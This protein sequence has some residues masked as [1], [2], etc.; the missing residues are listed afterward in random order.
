MT[1]VRV[2]VPVLQGKRKF[3][4]DKGRPW[5]V[6]EKVVL[7]ALGHKDLTASELAEQANVPRRL[8]V[9]S[10]IR[11]MRAGWIQMI[12]SNTGVVFQPTQ[13]GL[14]A[15]VADE[16]P[17][18]TRRMKRG[19]TFIV[20]QISGGVFRSRELPYLHKNVVQ[21][22]A[23]REP[24]IWM[25][26]PSRTYLD[27]IRPLVDAL[28]QDDERFIAMDP[29]GDRLAERWSL[30]R[31]RDGEP[32]GLSPRASPTLITAIKEA[33]KKW[34][35]GAPNPDLTYAPP[36]DIAAPIRV[37]GTHNLSIMSGDI[38][39]GGPDHR[40]VLES[41]LKK[42]R[43]RVIIHSTFIAEQ[44][45]NDLLPL[46]LD[47]Q[48][49]GAVIDIMWGQGE[50]TAEKKSTQKVALLL[51]AR[52]TEQKIDRIRV[53]PF[54]TDS[55]AKFLLADTG[56]IDQFNCVIGSCNWLYSGFESIE[57]SAKLRDPRIISEI[58]AELGELS[59]GRKG[60]WTDFTND[61]A[62]LSSYLGGLPAPAAG[63]AQVSLV[64]GPQHA[65]Q[66]RSARDEASNRILV[67][68]H[69]LSTTAHNA[70]LAPAIAAA[71][72]RNIAT[73]IYYGIKS[74][75]LTG[76][77]L[78]DIIVEGRQHSIKITPIHDPKL[79]AKLLAWDDDAVVITSQNWLSADPPDDKP[80]AEIGLSIRSPGIARQIID[81]LNAI[82]R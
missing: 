61:L 57:I 59:R 9:E 35:G 5:S 2:A 36:S 51:Q 46:M 38:L 70:V 42:A 53:H 18:V 74:G 40:D 48:K 13:S 7:V 45:F 39:V 10:L 78:S 64:L 50:Q 56:S 16:L 12:E 22:R 67:T 41:M 75:P 62:A 79:H 44:R 31:V 27:E 47:A 60:Y 6:L 14:L 11:L 72:E 20:E 37:L 58:V 4:F 49:R 43:H 82:R 30:V 28:F 1:V 15:A 66:V 80:R 17:S 52:L 71:K 81:R 21:E 54:S 32:D 69:R 8:I 76:P 55:H 26:R 68:S 63:K 29:A 73:E 65:E 33:A 25:E 23:A 3:H 34:T 77:G 19:M 24:I